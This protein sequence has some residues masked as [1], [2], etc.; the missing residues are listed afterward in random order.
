M[1]DSDHPYKRLFSHPEMMADL[2][3][4]FLS[5]DFSNL[6][7]FSTLTRCN[8]SYVTDDLREREDDIFWRVLY[9]DR[10]LLL[11]LLI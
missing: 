9:G 8:G 1:S 5:P 7:D 6:C 2:I 11:Y 3:R 4:G 10:T